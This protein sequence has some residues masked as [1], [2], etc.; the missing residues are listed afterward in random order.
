MPYS[1]HFM[2]NVFVSEL[3]VSLGMNTDKSTTRTICLGK[4]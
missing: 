1:Q 3:R 2:Q 4:R